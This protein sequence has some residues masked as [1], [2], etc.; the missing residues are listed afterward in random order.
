MGGSSRGQGWH[1]SGR[2]ALSHLSADDT[3]SYTRFMR[4]VLPKAVD[5]RVLGACNLRCAYCFGPRH[6]IGPKRSRELL[7]LRVRLH[8][9]GV[10]RIVFTGG[11]PLLAPDTPRL[12]RHAKRLGM[13]TILSTNGSRLPALHSRFM[14]CLDWIALPMDGPTADVHNKCRPGPP[15]FSW[16]TSSIHLTRDKYPN[17]RIKLGT[18]VQRKNLE[19]VHRIPEALGTSLRPDTWK[20]YEVSFSNYAHDNRVRLRLPRRTID[21]A[22]ERCELA[23][24][25]EGWRFVSY[26]NAH[27]DGQYLFVEPNGDAMVIEDGVETVVGNLIDDFTDTAAAV[28]ARLHEE[29]LVKNQFRTYPPIEQVER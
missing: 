6:N 9:S 14:P 4:P 21:S 27:R 18:V 26:R 1:S 25:A 19:E 15:S 22:F 10:E 11:E 13:V 29:R 3:S 12:I 2:S 24:G 7:D 8:D 23:A 16:T 17:T 28:G 5:I 20:L